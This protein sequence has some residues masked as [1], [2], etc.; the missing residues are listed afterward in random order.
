MNYIK[1]L[2]LGKLNPARQ[3]FTNG[4]DYSKIMQQ[5]SEAYDELSKTL[6]DDNK[7]LLERLFELQFQINDIE[8][9][10]NYAIG[11]RD[12]SRLM[13]DILLGRN[14]NLNSKKWYTKGVY[15]KCWKY[16]E[17]PKL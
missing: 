9:V 6:N 14:E 11:F 3:Q 17:N 2:Y 4:S 7:K 13:I 1:D 16:K 8:S 5:E 10:D 12:G 15:N